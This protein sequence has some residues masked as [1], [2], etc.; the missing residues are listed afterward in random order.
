MATGRDSDRNS[1]RLWCPLLSASLLLLWPALSAGQTPPRRSSDTTPEI[2]VEASRPD[3]PAALNPVE[4]FGADFVAQTDGFTAD[5]VLASVTADL[6]GTEQVVLI[7]GRESQ[8]DI[9]TI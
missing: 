8:V 6:P 4:R 7:D 9:S 5:E 1:G 3:A 2:R